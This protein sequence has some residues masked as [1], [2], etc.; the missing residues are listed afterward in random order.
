MAV[1]GY[2][3]Y[4]ENVKSQVTLN[5][6]HELLGSKIAIYTTLVTPIAKYTLTVTPVVAAIEN[7]Y[8][9]FYYNNRAVSLLV[10]TLLLISSVIVALT[11]PFFEYLMALVGAFLGATVSIMRWGYELVI[12]IGIIL[13]GISVVI[14]GTYTS[15]KQIIGELHANV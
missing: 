5:L 15:M 1:L 8:L 14:I 6:P 3:M 11:V 4:G 2:L 10:R 9:M 13:V 7:S 12:I